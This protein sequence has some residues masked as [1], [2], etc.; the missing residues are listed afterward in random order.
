MG[1]VIVKSLGSGQ[2]FDLKSLYPDDYKSFTNNNF[3]IKTA[4]TASGIDRVTISGNTQYIGFSGKIYKS[5]NSSTGILTAYNYITGN[6][7]GLTSKANVTVYYVSDQSQLTSLGTG[8]SFNLRNY[9]VDGS[10]I[11]A[12]T[13]ESLDLEGFKNFLVSGVNTYSSS[14]SR[15]IDGTWQITGS[16]KL[17]K[18]NNNGTITL[19]YSGTDS[20][21][22]AETLLPVTA[23]FYMPYKITV[24]AEPSYAGKVSGGGTYLYNKTAQLTATPESDYRFVGWWNGETQVSNTTS[25]SLAHIKSAQTLTAKFVPK[26][27]VSVQIEGQEYATSAT[28]AWGT[29]TNVVLTAVPNENNG[30]FVGWYV[31]SGNEASTLISNNEVA[32]YTVT[33]NTVFI[34]KFAR[35]YAINLSIV[36]NGTVDITRAD[37]DKNNVRFSAVPASHYTFQKY[38]IEPNESLMFE[39]PNQAYSYVLTDDITVTAFFLEDDK[40]HI[41]SG[42]NI[43]SFDIYVSQMDGYYGFTAKLFARP[44]PGYNFVHWQDGNTD[45]P[46]TITVTEDIN[47]YA[48]Y[49]KEFDENGKYQYRCYIKDQLALG[50]SPK[51]FMRVDSFTANR[52]LLT[53]ANSTVT[54]YK[55]DLKDAVDIINDGDI[56]ILYDPKGKTLYQ[57]VITSRENN[58]FRCSQ[59]QS[60]YKGEWVYDTGETPPESYDGLWTMK[61]YAY[62]TDVECP[63]PTIY[64]GK[65]VTAAYSIEDDY[66]GK[67]IY[68]QA[69]IPAKAFADGAK[70]GA[71]A[72]TYIWTSRPFNIP[73]RFQ[74]H[75]GGTFYLNGEMIGELP[76]RMNGGSEV[77]DLG[78]SFKK[79]KNELTVC[80]RS[81]CDTQHDED[82]QYNPFGENGWAVYLTMDAFAEYSSSST[83]KVGDLCVHSN[84]LFK[85]TTAIKKPE[86][87][88]DG[89]WT[90][91]YATFKRRNEADN[92]LPNMAKL[93]DHPYVLG[94]TS[95][96]KK[97]GYLEKAIKNILFDYS[98]GLLIG[99]EYTDLQVQKRLGGMINYASDN[100][101]TKN[102]QHII[103]TEST[104]ASLVTAELGDTMDFEKFIYWLYEAYGIIFD[105][106]IGFSGDNNYVRIRT[107]PYSSMKVGN[108]VYAIKDISPIQTVEETNRLVI[109]SSDGDYRKTVVLTKSNDTAQDP[110]GNAATA[111]RFELTNSKI[112]YSDD[113]IEDLVAAYL[114]NEIYNHKLSFKLLLR[115]YIYEF[116]DFKLG[117]PLEVYYRHDNKQDFY[118][119]VLTGYQIK[120]NS[121]EDITEVEFTCGL[122]RQKLTQ[123]MTLGRI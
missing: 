94:I 23:Y 18:S 62:P 35:K 44:Y 91:S 46:R 100:A 72:T 24:S 95:V 108:N 34:A 71:Q 83:Y 10:T 49:W 103:A 42:T 79:G 20:D 99:S 52:D 75:Q 8:T 9:T 117:M 98:K 22:N 59:M 85:C 90:R 54:V 41:L 82:P 120:K 11:Y 5:Y 31:K 60:F 40:Y 74:S 33:A 111:N 80:Y 17:L 122:V 101:N 1:A 89:H 97:D 66:V 86:P 27:T 56:L 43:P 112:V 123:K 28:W 87:W 64:Y 73:V 16:T 78:C 37:N 21:Q 119:T 3:F 107:C 45:N 32:N 55:T 63:D 88:T 25:Y 13:Y 38:R 81:K 53:T 4:A 93:K 15:S 84:G 116:E 14:H 29:K 47:V 106:D 113:P 61:T 70:Y 19:A 30:Q 67:Y 69:L 12:D 121:G 48:T 77:Y 109:F 65:T 105:F 51:A 50:K 114:P 115:N 58:V 118:N 2:S 7:S 57:G 92:V 26:Y 76:W 102:G 96:D 104:T 39:V 68:Q 110:T 36:G 6:K